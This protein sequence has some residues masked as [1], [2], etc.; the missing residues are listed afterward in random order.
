MNQVFDVLTTLET[1]NPARRRCAHTLN[2]V[3]RVYLNTSEL[4]CRSPSWKWS[5]TAGGGEDDGAEC[6]EG[7]TAPSNIRLTNGSQDVIWSERIE[8]AV[9][10]HKSTDCCCYPY[11]ILLYAV[12]IK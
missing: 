10:S 4:S 6:G 7:A 8:L 3:S 2:A 9:S 11:T 1:G 12:I 5:L